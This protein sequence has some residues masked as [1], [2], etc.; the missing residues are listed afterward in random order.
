MM[1]VNKKLLLMYGLFETWMTESNESWQEQE[2]ESGKEKVWAG[3]S[4]LGVFREQ[5]GGSRMEEEEVWDKARLGGKRQVMKSFVRQGQKLGLYSKHKEST[6]KFRA[7]NFR[8]L[9]YILK[10]SSWYFPR[11]RN[12][13]HSSKLNSSIPP[14]SLGHSL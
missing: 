6:E 3:K 7:R 14:L 4:E 1:K 13:I 2:T 11:Y 12:Y 10:V 9:I 8:N 5:K